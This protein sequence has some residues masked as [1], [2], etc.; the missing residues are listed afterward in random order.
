MDSGSLRDS[1]TASFVKNSKRTA[2]TFLRNGQIETEISYRQLQRDSR[3]VAHTF[4]ELGVQKTDRVVFYIQKSLL[5]VMAHLALQK[6]GAISV[7]LNPGF[8]KSELAYLLQDADAKL[9]LT[10]PDNAR[11]DVADRIAGWLNDH[12]H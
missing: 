8:K 1:F 10:E 6:I 7:P 3:R 4:Q 2:I 12:G 11:D 9:I 5:F